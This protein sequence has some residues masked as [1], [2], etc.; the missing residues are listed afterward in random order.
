[1][2]LVPRIA[3]SGDHMMFDIDTYWSGG[4]GNPT[5]TINRVTIGN[6][7]IESIE[8]P[9][10]HHGAEHIENQRFYFGHVHG[11]FSWN[12]SQR[13][14]ISRGNSEWLPTLLLVGWMTTEIPLQGGSLDL[15][16]PNPQRLA[17]DGCLSVLSLSKDTILT[18]NDGLREYPFRPHPSWATFNNIPA[19]SSG[20]VTMGSWPESIL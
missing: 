3:R 6:E 14:A 5:S 10:L 17:E 8:V 2:M 7:I 16:W 11:S 9:D 15:S 18:G 20:L 13:S 12:S 19:R 1:M 4:P